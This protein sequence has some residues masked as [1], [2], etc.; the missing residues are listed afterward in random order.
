MSDF[1]GKVAHLKE[2]E[3]LVYTICLKLL[4]HESEA[5]QLAE[6]VLCELFR[7]SGYWLLEPAERPGSVLG[8]CMRACAARQ[9]RQWSR[10]S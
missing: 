2:V 8:H 7:D 9:K 10:I 6:A 1:N 3:S 4:E 5:L